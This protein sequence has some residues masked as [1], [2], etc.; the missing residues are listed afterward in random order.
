MGSQYGVCTR[1][2][3][4]GTPSNRRDHPLLSLIDAKAAF[5]R[6]RG[7]G[8]S[9]CDASVRCGG[10]GFCG[11]AHPTEHPYHSERA[12]RP[13]ARCCAP[14]ACAH[15][16]GV[17]ERGGQRSFQNHQPAH[18]G[19]PRHGCQGV[20]RC[21]RPWLERDHHLSLRQLRPAGAATGNRRR[22]VR[23]RINIGPPAILPGASWSLWPDPHAERRRS[24]VIFL[25]LF[26]ELFVRASRL[27]VRG[28]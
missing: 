19:H 11:T 1:A 3:L 15:S 22:A 2:V 8:L 25:V 6:S 20:S 4:T 24:A 28:S 14:L 12:V 13:G 17:S 5:A 23:K 18:R 21:L 26:C 16:A 27:S 7:R 9:S 10:D